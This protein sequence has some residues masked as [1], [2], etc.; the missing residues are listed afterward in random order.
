MLHKRC[1]TEGWPGMIPPI[2]KWTPAFK[3]KF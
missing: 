3:F 2:P 1:G